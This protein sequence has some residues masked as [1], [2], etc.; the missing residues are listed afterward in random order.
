MTLLTPL[1]RDDKVE[2]FDFFAHYLFCVT[3]R[4]GNVER[5]VKNHH[6]WTEVRLQ[7]DDG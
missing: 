1:M 3:S 4:Y 7:T 5:I 2:A 6:T